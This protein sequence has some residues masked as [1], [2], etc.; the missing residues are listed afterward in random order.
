MNYL[1]TTNETFVFLYRIPIK[2]VNKLP[3]KHT[4]EIIVCN[5][6]Y[7]SILVTTRIMKLIFVILS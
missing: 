7:L 1:T 3:F 4:L 6:I 2:Y 5:N